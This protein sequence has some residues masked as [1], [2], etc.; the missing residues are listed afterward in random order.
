MSLFQ[1]TP[2]YFT[3]QGKALVSANPPKE[4]NGKLV[5]EDVVLADETGTIS[6]SLWESLINEIQ[7]NCSYE[8][9]YVKLRKRMGMFILNNYTI[10]KM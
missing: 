5:K 7:D 3:I 6:L 1:M 10:N 8:V 9:T 2:K 4:V